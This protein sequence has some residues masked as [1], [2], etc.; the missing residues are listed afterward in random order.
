MRD[1]QAIFACSDAGVRSHEKRRQASA[2]QNVAAVSRAPIHACALKCAGAPALW[3]LRPDCG[4]RSGL[5]K[6]ERTGRRPMFQH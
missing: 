5:R 3:M 6:Q 4:I 1:A 2:L